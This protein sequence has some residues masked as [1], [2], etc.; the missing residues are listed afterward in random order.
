MCS[1]EP[2]G[3]AKSHGR[4]HGRELP[5]RQLLSIAVCLVVTAY[6]LSFLA[7]SSASTRAFYYSRFLGAVVEDAPNDLEKFTMEVPKKFNRILDG[8]SAT[9]TASVSYTFHNVHV[10]F[11]PVAV[12]TALFLTFSSSYM[13]R[14]ATIHY[15]S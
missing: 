1:D 11:I 9:P 10:M 4:A 3:A 7:K 8:S 15:N 2:N 6:N 12:V 5:R 13:W 14:R